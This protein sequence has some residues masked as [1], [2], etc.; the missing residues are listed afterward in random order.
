MEE[1]DVSG[2]REQLLKES[3]QEVFIQTFKKEGENYV[4][5][6]TQ[7]PTKSKLKDKGDHYVATFS[8]SDL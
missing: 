1:T 6:Y 4:E 7:T 5:D 3:P 2:A 8:G